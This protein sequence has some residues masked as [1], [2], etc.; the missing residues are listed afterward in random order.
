MTP[1]ASAAD[2]VSVS[3]GTHRPE[4]SRR[5]RRTGG[6][7]S[8]RGAFV[9]LSQMEVIARAMTELPLPLCSVPYCQCRVTT[10]SPP[11]PVPETVGPGGASDE[12][13]PAPSQPPPSTPPSHGGGTRARERHWR[14]S[15]RS[16][17]RPCGAQVT[18]ADDPCSSFS[19]VSSCTVHIRPAAADQRSSP[20]VCTRRHSAAAIVPALVAN[21]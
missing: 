13:G 12:P 2:N 9:V 11:L 18:G 15:P 5:I 1:G 16:E 3:C 7:H 8:H 17:R 6:R 19:G 4:M 14:R 10:D 20:P 21:R